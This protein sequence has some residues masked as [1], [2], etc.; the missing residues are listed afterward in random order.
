M[1]LSFEIGLITRALTRAFCPPLKPEDF[2]WGSSGG[3]LTATVVLAPQFRVSMNPSMFQNEIVHSATSGQWE[4]SG[5]HPVLRTFV[6]FIAGDPCKQEHQAPSHYRL[7]YAF[8]VNDPFNAGD[9]ALFLLIRAHLLLP[10]Q[11]I[12]SSPLLGTASVHVNRLNRFKPAFACPSPAHWP[13]TGSILL[14]SSD[15]LKSR[16]AKP[17]RAGGRA[18]QFASR[19]SARSLRIRKR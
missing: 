6:N 17:C 3:A 2:N 11:L 15:G 8:N 14:T 9:G 19:P 13:I 4:A 1:S 12:S 16:R 5:Y 10:W 7:A 18:S